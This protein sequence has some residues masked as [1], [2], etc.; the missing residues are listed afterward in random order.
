M[1]FLNVY[2]TSWCM[3]VDMSAPKVFFTQMWYFVGQTDT[4][5]STL[6][7]SPQK[8]PKLH[9]N[10]PSFFFFFFPSVRWV[11]YVSCPQS[12]P[13]AAARHLM[14]RSAA[15]GASATAASA[16]ARPRTRGSST[17]HAASATTGSAPHTTRKLAMVRTMI[18]VCWHITQPD[19]VEVSCEGRCTG[20]LLLGDGCQRWVGKWCSRA[21]RCGLTNRLS[22]WCLV[23][24]PAR[25]WEE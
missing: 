14:A 17:V 6:D 1:G 8:F 5:G 10:W 12:R 16:S 9:N 11:V 7:P 2:Q 25:C 13:C 15:G 4:G 19:G 20:T 22:S 18:V 3:K 24:V 21:P 23:S